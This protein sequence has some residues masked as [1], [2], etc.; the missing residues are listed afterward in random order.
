MTGC[1]TGM[2]LP[3]TDNHVD[4]ERVEFQ[5]VAAPAGALGREEGGAAAQE[6]IQHNVAARGAI[7]NG[8][9]H[10]GHWLHRGVEYREIPLLGAAPERVGPRIAPDIAAVAAV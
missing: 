9:D 10:H 1:V 3:A 2:A 4:V 7:Q 6:G 8:V 5:A